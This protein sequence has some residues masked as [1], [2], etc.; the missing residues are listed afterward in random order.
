MKREL[1]IKGIKFYIG[2]YTPRKNTFERRLAY[3]LYVDGIPTDYKFVRIRE[4]QK[5]V[6]KNYWIWL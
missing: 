2:N 4:A 6:Q 1:E 5:F 3:Q